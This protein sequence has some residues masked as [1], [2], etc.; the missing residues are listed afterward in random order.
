MALNV[1]YE[2]TKKITDEN[3]GLLTESNKG[4]IVIGYWMS[5]IAFPKWEEFT[6]GI[7]FL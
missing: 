5:V 7:R 4:C 2:I 3:R 1:A 6:K